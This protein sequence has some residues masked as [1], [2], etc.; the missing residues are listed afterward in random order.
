MSVRNSDGLIRLGVLALPL[1]ALLGLGGLYSGLKLGSG[2]IIASSDN[3]AVVSS[4]Y[5]WSQ[6]VGSAL[7]LTVLIFGVMALYAYLVNTGQKPL[8]LGALVL[9]IVGIAL[10]LTEVGVYAYTVPPSA[11]RSSVV[12]R[13][14]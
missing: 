9:S 4:G 11:A 7:A 10:D 12:I 13:R 6:F 5:F 1:A 14:A 2:G 8:A 3:Q